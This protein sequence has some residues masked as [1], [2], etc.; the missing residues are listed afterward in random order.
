MSLFNSFSYSVS[1]LSPALPGNTSGV[2]AYVSV[3]AFKPTVLYPGNSS[4]RNTKFVYHLFLALRK[5]DF[6]KDK[7][8]LEYICILQKLFQISIKF[9]IYF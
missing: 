5:F 8:K 6:T 1:P 9:Y 7:L 2:T 4:H 3:N